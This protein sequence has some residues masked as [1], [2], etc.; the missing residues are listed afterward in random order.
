MD[1]ASP[2][3]AIELTTAERDLIRTALRVLIASLGRE[4]ADQIDEAQA[5]LA[6]ID[7]PAA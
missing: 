6:K 4:D 7:R 3:T 2:A 1:E 5:L